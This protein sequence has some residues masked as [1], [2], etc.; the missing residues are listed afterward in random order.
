M[1]FLA[2]HLIITPILLPLL[3]GAAMLLVND[4]HYRLRA[5]L[6]LVSTLALL[7]IAIMLVQLADVPA[8]DASLG[9]AYL[10]GNWPIPVAIVLVV[11][12]LSALMLTLSAVLALCM[13][14]YALARWHRAGLH[15]HSLVQFLLMGLNGAFLTGDLFNLFVFFEVLLA[16]SY[17]LVLHGAGQQRVEAGLKYIAINLAASLLFLIGVSMIYGVTGP[18]N[19]ADLAMR[20]PDIASADRPLLEVGAAILA[21]AFLVKA[22][23]WPLGLWLPNTY[24]AASAPVAAMFVIMSKVGIYAV[25]RVWMLVFGPHA[26]ASAYFGGDWLLYAGLAT[27]TVAAIAVLA[28]QDSKQLAGHSLLVS[29]GTLLAAIGTGQAGVVG[30]ALFYLISSSLGIGAFYLLIELTERNKTAGADILAVTWEAFGEADDVLPGEEEVG[31][32][33]PATMA[34]LGISFILCAL[35]IAGLPP[36]SGFIAKF[37]LLTAAFNPE[38]LGATGEPIS[39]TGWLLLAALLLSGLT[40]LIALARAGMKIFWMPASTRVPRVRLIEMAP[41]GTLLILC[42]VLTV[43]AG[44]VL[45]YTQAAAE[46]LFAPE[47]Y[48]ESVFGAPRA[49]ELPQEA[50]L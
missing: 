27:V 50:E 15:F 19:M 11:D 46:E 7:V 32:A 18:L 41:I 2:D 49:G 44:P 39:T 43:Q 22:A 38:G 21:V 13:Q 45:R 28:T 25:L 10:L 42:M 12:R 17:S 6:G 31:V 35:L 1:S 37:A 5:A 29:S 4:R 48:V 36:V 16:A 33:I 24:G 26:G 20:L 8:G 34:L 47:S 9:R 3:A 40:A 30:A 23:I 14:I